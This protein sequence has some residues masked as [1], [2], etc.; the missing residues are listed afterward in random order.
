MSASDST[1]KARQWYISI[2]TFR[3]DREAMCKA[4]DVVHRSLITAID[5]SYGHAVTTILHNVVAVHRGHREAIT[6]N[7]RS[8][9]IPVPPTPARMPCATRGTDNST[10][11]C[12][13]YFA[14]QCQLPHGR[15]N[16]MSSLFVYD[17]CML[18]FPP[19]QAIRPSLITLLLP[20]LLCPHLVPWGVALVEPA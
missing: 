12:T 20:V 9:P 15:K 17:M 2:G 11:L 19:N 7:P 13:P 14:V 5:Q 3:C 16:C 10:I 8:V 1:K 4:V 6:V 18:T